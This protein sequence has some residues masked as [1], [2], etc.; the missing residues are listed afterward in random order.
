M[1]AEVVLKDVGVGENGAK[2]QVALEYSPTQLKTRLQN[3]CLWVGESC[4]GKGI[5]LELATKAWVLKKN[6]SCKFS[7]LPTRKHLSRI[8]ISLCPTTLPWGGKTRHRWGNTKTNAKLP[9]HKGLAL[10]YLMENEM[11]FE[12][13][14]VE[15]Q[16]CSYPIKDNESLNKKT[17]GHLK[18]KPKSKLLHVGWEQGKILSRN[19]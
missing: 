13:H 4:W 9:H 7:Q 17:E 2:E 11:P 14:V 3:R 10:A 12:H 5:E 18:T 8:Q 16:G 19:G 6:S 15:W 1:K